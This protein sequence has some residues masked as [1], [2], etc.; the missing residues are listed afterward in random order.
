[1]K[2]KLIV[3]AVC[4]L[5]AGG[6]GFLGLKLFREGGFFAK[7]EVLFSDDFPEAD[8]EKIRGLIPEDFKLKNDVKISYSF[9][10]KSK[11]AGFLVDVLVPTTDFYDTRNSLSEAEFLELVKN[12]DSSVISIRELDSSRKLLAVGENYYLDSF[13]SGAE[14]KYLDVESDREEDAQAVVDVLTPEFSKPNMVPSS[15]T[16]LSFV[17]TGVTALAREMNAKLEEVGD[18]GY[19]S[20]GVSSFVSRFDLVHTSNESSFSEMAS[21]ENICSD[22]RFIGTLTGMSLDI[23]EL[24][25]NHNVD[26]G[27]EDAITTVEV[28]EANGIKIVGGG[29]DFSEAR[30]ALKINQKSNNITML[31]YNQSTGGATTGDAPGANPYSEED[32]RTRILE[33]KERGDSVIVD[34]QYFECSEY[35]NEGEDT[36]CDY[37]NSSAGDQIGLFRSLIDMGADV[38]VGTSAH[39]P[40]TFEKY[41]NG[42][43]YYGLGN[44]FFDQYYW[45]GTTRS[46]GLVHYF[47]NNKLIQTRRFGTVYDSALQTRI[48]SE[49]EE[50]SFIERLNN[51]RPN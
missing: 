6:L 3:G 48:M 9:S 36:T 47:W 16:T 17:Q 41:N 25:G 34:I 7:G 2:K 33:A 14:F 5:F 37:A 4:F 12:N 15:A 39:Q 45:P 18:A 19:F 20:A 31:A 46:L 29:R 49:E 21:K 51:A 42:E 27:E 1:M 28:Y 22:P 43:I 40:Q 11:D 8:A 23:V 32:A 38:V 24:T 44:L 30:E 10:E 50:A 13:N 35:A 26:C